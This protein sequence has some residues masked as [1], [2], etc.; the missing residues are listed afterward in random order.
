MGSIDRWLF[1]HSAQRER[2]GSRAAE[3]R[4]YEPHQLSLS[5]VASLQCRFRFT[6]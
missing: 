6:G 3:H 2:I 4:L 5:M 1:L